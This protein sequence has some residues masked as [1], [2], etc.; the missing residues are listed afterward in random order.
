MLTGSV[1]DSALQSMIFLAMD[2]PKNLGGYPE[3]ISTAQ[4]PTVCKNGLESVQGR[5]VLHYFQYCLFLL[6]SGILGKKSSFFILTCCTSFSSHSWKV[7]S[8]ANKL[9][10]ADEEKKKSRSQNDGS[11][12]GGGSVMFLWWDS[13]CC[14]QKTNFALLITT[15]DLFHAF[16]FI[17]AQITFDYWGSTI[18]DRRE[19]LK[20]YSFLAVFGSLLFF[21]S[22][23]DTSHD[24]KLF[25]NK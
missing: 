21:P 9:G 8:L 1:Q 11:C 3:F 18:L 14:Y 24:I 22:I 20:D 7:Q 17:Y 15:E 25:C 16:L 2:K 10:K 13:T 4:M 12:L 23:S 6:R 19:F 5:W